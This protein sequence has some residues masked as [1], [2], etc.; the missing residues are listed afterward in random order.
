MT[1]HNTIS[2][3]SGEVASFNG[4]SQR[5]DLVNLLIMY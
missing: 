3:A 5:T 2:S 1:N 4:F